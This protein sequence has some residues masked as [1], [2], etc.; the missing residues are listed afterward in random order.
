MTGALQ[1]EQNLSDLSNPSEALKSL[2]LDSDGRRIQGH[3]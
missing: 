1:K 3:C 2:G